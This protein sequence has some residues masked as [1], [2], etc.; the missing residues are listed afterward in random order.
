MKTEL[1]MRVA[2]E[3]FLKQ[4]IVGGFERVYEIGKNFRNEGIDYNHNPEFTACEFYW[5]YAD[6]ND[7]MQLTE[8]LLS[9][10]VQ[11]VCG[12]LKI[13]IKRRNDD[14]EIEI[15]F[16]T[17][18]PRISIMEEL[19]KVTGRSF[20]ENLASDAANEFFDKLCHERGVACAAPRTTARLID[21]L[22]GHYIEPRCT[23]PTFLTDHPQLMS[24]LAKPHRSSRGLT[25]RFELFINEFEIVNAY[26]ELNDPF[27][28][29]DTFASQMLDKT[30]GDDEAQPYDHDFVKALEHG[31]PPTAGFG[32]GLDRLVMLLTN[33]DNIQ[34]VILFPAMKPLPVEAVH[35]PR[36]SNKH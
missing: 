31:L 15:D 22:V 26:T 20:P 36:D 32:I 5:A 30:K 4:L 23:N 13:R 2:P 6:Y 10:M 12:S 9:S 14:S 1:T 27:I 3:L 17:P 33:S 29:R 35:D 16:K 28:Q 8:E 19:Q 21:K 18:W 34:E 24:P 25:E 11:Q 7:V